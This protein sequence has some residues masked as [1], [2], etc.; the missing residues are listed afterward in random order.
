MAQFFFYSALT[1]NLPLSTSSWPY[2]W[3]HPLLS[4]I[5]G[6]RYELLA[7]KSS[8]VFLF[9]RLCVLLLY[10][11]VLFA[12]FPFIFRMLLV[13]CPGKV[14][15]LLIFDETEVTGTGYSVCVSSIRKPDYN[16][17]VVRRIVKPVCCMMC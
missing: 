16:L 15:T 17:K 5:F 4:E 7:M 2:Y 9:L 8:G 13:L 10:L 6:E 14:G 11:S 3:H 12:V 1:L